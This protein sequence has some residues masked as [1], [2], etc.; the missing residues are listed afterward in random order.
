MVHTF[1]ILVRY[2]IS[3]TRFVTWMLNLAS[4]F[5]PSCALEEWLALSYD[6]SDLLAQQSKIRRASCLEQIAGQLQWRE[7]F[8]RWH[9]V[10]CMHGACS[11]FPSR[12]NSAGPSRK[13]GRASCRERG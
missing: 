8:C 10:Q 1:G 6:T 12:S 11:V 13:I 4:H 7:Y 5:K 9:S 3:G 2:G